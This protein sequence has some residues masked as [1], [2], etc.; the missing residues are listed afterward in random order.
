M[1]KETTAGAATNLNTSTKNAATPLLGVLGGM[2]PLATVDFLQKLI[3]ETPASGDADHVPVIV[4]S[5]PQIKD[6]PA[7]ITGDGESPLPQMLKGIHILRQA[8]AR[9]IAIPCNT[10]HYWYD[11]LV[12][13]G[14]LPII[15]IADAVCD[16]LAVRGISTGTVGMIATNGTI[17]AGFFQQRL[18]QRGLRFIL[19]SAD[20]Q[21]TLV[22]PAI[23]CVKR[24]DLSR[25]HTLATRAVQNL[26]TAGAEAVILACTEIPPAIEFAPAA[27]S[28]FCVDATR[29]LAMACAAWW[30]DIRKK[31]S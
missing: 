15:H 1:R 19:S 13:K 16:E 31:S 30:Q 17:A 7:A 22:L 26:R 3:E 11:E 5:V 24:N 23:G 14:G 20:D 12:S 4:Y 18:A 21:N 8:G 28:E 9:V 2:G 10:A 25:A 6:R 27:V 29:V